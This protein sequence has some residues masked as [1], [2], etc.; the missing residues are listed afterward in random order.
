MSKVLFEEEDDANLSIK[1]NTK[2]AEKFEYRKKAEELSNLKQKYG[3]DYDDEDQSSSE[4][5]DSDAELLTANMDADILR[6][7]SLIKSKDPR[8]YDKSA[9][10]YD[11]PNPLKASEDKKSDKDKDEKMTLKDYE[12]REL[13]T[14]GAEGA[15][16]EEQDD[17]ELQLDAKAPSYYEEQDSIKSQLKK[18]L[19]AMDEDEEEDLFAVKVKTE[20][21]VEEEEEDFLKWLKGEEKKVKNVKVGEMETLKRY[22]TDP[23]LGNNE[24]FLRDYVLTKGW[25]EKDD[26]DYTPNKAK[27][28]S[29]VIVDDDED[30]DVVDAADDF[31]RKYNFRYEEEGGT[32]IKSYPRVIDDSLRKGDDRRKNERTRRREAKK[33][34]KEEKKEELKRLKNLKKQEI[35][36]KIKKIQEIGGIKENTNIDLEGEFD[37]DKYEKQMAGMFDESYYEEEEDLEKPVFDD[38]PTLDIEQ[39]EDED[40]YEEGEG[41]MGDYGEGDEEEEGGK[42]KKKKSKDVV[43][44]D[45][46]KVT[47]KDDDWLEGDVDID[48]DADYAGEMDNTVGDAPESEGKKTLSKSQKKKQ[49]KHLGRLLKDMEAANTKPEFDPESMNFDQYLNEYYN[50]DYEDMIGDTPVRF[51]YRTV[52][53][54]D[55][56]LTPEEVLAADDKE[57]NTWAPLKALTKYRPSK[58]DKKDVEKYASLPP[59]KKAQIIPSA[60]P[61][62]RHQGIKKKTADGPQAGGEKMK[63]NKVPKDTEGQ[64]EKDNEKKKDKEGEGEARG[65]AEGK[66]KR[67]KKKKTTQDNSTVGE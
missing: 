8:I 61:W 20:G 18:S 48:M 58:Y 60:L 17:Y 54:N 40:D 3:D 2:Y 11:E 66:K 24:K 43:E 51:K 39:W 34:E 14:K 52:M 28:K 44:E 29:N 6:T 30:A 22:W 10:F 1:V 62:W 25:M 26:D 16:N 21:E 59:W 46:E 32:E 50:L 27:S 33:K 15:F 49:K 65:D 19:A 12:R 67:K 64:G 55:Y 37:P 7:I 5:E 35:M 45:V 38:D 4:E 23:N 41:E 31:E 36:E 47:R 57:L 9:K 56:G 53:P 42:K 63:K 13:L